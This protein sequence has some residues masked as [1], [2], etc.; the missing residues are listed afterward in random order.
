VRELFRVRY[1]CGRSNATGTYSFLS[2]KTLLNEFNHFEIDM[3]IFQ[4][5]IDIANATLRKEKEDILNM[6]SAI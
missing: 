1:H 2:K 5:A 3:N 6:L 4:P